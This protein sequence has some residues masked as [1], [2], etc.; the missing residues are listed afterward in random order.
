MRRTVFVTVSRT[1]EGC[2]V[3]VV[4]REMLMT[5][6]TLALAA[7]TILATS[8]IALAQSAAPVPAPVG[9]PAEHRLAA[10]MV[11]RPA[12]TGEPETAKHAAGT[13]L[14][15]KKMD[16]VA[17]VTGRAGPKTDGLSAPQ[18]DTAWRDYIYRAVIVRSGD[19]G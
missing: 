12:T 10:T 17:M 1:Y 13:S 3:G 18:V 6:T 14:I 2:A 9:S 4:Y 19:G 8:A 15:C 7:A 16:G 11:C 5:K